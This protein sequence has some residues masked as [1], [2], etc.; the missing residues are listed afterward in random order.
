MTSG[1]SK[2]M[3][4]VAATHLKYVAKNFPLLFYF[5]KHFIVFCIW[6]GITGN[7]VSRQSST[8]NP[9]TKPDYSFKPA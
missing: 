4:V 5:E 7:R 3:G 8:L 1:T 6:I 2:K 9:F